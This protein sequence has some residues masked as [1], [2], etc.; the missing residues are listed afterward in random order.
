MLSIEVDSPTLDVVWL[1]CPFSV[2]ILM[3]YEDKNGC[4]KNGYREFLFE[5]GIVESREDI[6]TKIL[7]CMIFFDYKGV[8]YYIYVLQSARFILLPSDII[9]NWKI[10]F[11]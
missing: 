4:S 2:L 7:Y 1:M 6:E 10:S 3:K 5:Y 8:P 9:F 11:F